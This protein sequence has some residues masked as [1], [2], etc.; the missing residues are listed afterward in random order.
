MDGRTD[1]L[2]DEVPSHKLPNYIPAALKL[3]SH[4]YEIMHLFHRFQH[5]YAVI[6]A[7][8]VHGK[9]D[10][11]GNLSVALTAYL[12]VMEHT[13]TQ[14]VCPSNYYYWHGLAR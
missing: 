13:P 14:L 7:N 4:V 1:R 11:R 12:V 3:S 6:L 10:K 2:T 8:K 5:L 9:S